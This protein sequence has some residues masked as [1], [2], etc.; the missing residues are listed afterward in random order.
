MIRNI[1]AGVFPVIFLFQA[2]CGQDLSGVTTNISNPP[3]LNAK[4]T[5]GF[6][7]DLLR[8]PTDVS[9]D[10]AKGYMSLNFPFEQNGLVPDSKSD[11]IWSDIY[12]QLS[13]SDTSNSL[14]FKPQA[15]AAQYAN[16]TIRVDVPMLGGVATFSN[17]ENVYINYANVLGNSTIKLNYDTTIAS[18]G[19][20][21]S[22]AL[23]LLGTVTVPV[24]ASL[25]WQTMTFGYAYKFFRDMVV[26]VNVHRHLFH[27]DMLAKVDADIL[28]HVKVEQSSDSS[29]GILDGSSI[30]IDKDINYSHEKVYGQASG[31]YDA[32]AWSSSFGIKFWRFTLTSR[33]GIDTK[34]H[35]TFSANYR[36]PAGIIDKQ[37][38]E[39]SDD[40]SDPQKLINSGILNDIQEGNVDSIVYTT[41]EPARWK[42]PSGHTISFEI[43]PDKLSLSYTKIIGDIEMYHEHAETLSTGGIKRRTDLDVGISV[44]NVIIVSAHLY[45]AF[46]NAGMFTMDIRVNDQKHILGKAYRNAH[47]ARLTW[48][49]DAMLPVINFGASFGIK[50]QL[51]FEVDLLP[52][53]AVKTGLTYNF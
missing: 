47:L 30:S 5:F 43:I 37:T 16:T 28:G 34:A 1:F 41:H 26:A 36:V 22:I 25:G 49:N 21:Q 20:S 29:T 19:S 32:E 14:K 24:E 18:S 4:L 27:I 10:Y 51:G 13:S 42:L 48:N 2:V 23:Y 6:N 46:V 8:S 12:K 9:F 52:L 7:Y 31:H 53:P 17:L 15:S 35:G 38:F 40:I 11:E 44:D 3:T 33:L 50:T 39:I 45:S